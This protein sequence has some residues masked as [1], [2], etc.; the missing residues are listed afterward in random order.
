MLCTL[1]PAERKVNKS[2]GIHFSAC[3]MFMSENKTEKGSLNHLCGHETVIET[4]LSRLELKRETRTVT[5]S[6]KKWNGKRVL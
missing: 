2:M 4:A 6:V 3:S 5:H 1:V